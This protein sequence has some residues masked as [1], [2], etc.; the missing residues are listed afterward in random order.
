MSKF[1]EILILTICYG[2]LASIAT[3]P[4]LYLLF[5]GDTTT[6]IGNFHNP[7][8]PGTLWF[9]WWLSHSL[10]KGLDFFHTD[11]LSYPYGENLWCT[12]G[13][14]LTLFLSYPVNK[15]LGL[16]RGYNVTAFI[17]LILNCIAGFLLINTIIKN[18]Y[19]AFLGGFIIGINQFTLRELAGGRLDQLA[20]FWFL[21]FLWSLVKLKNTQKLKFIFFSALLFIL[22]ALSSWHYGIISILLVISWSITAIFK[23]NYL[24]FRS[25]LSALSIGFLVLSFVLIFFIPEF[26]LEYSLPLTN[27]D[28]F[29]NYSPFLKMMLNNSLNPMALFFVFRFSKGD[30]VAIKISPFVFILSFI[31][32]IMSKR[33]KESDVYWNNLWIIS[34]ILSLGPLLRLNL[35]VIKT[36][37]HTEILLPFYFLA[38]YIPFF[39]RFFWPNRFLLIFFVSSAI[40]IMTFIERWFKAKEN[41]KKAIFLIGFIFII[42]AELSFH[43]GYIFPFQATAIKVPDIYFK[44][45]DLPDGVVLELPYRKGARGLEYLY[46]QTIHKKK[47]LNSSFGLWPFEIVPKKHRRLI[48]NFDLSN[49]GLFV[50]SEKDIEYLKGLGIK[51]IV[52][53]GE[54][55]LIGLNE[56]KEMEK[57]LF[58]LLGEPSISSPG[59]KTYLF[60]LY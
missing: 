36:G 60:I 12:M 44:L 45:K 5:S 21:F 37:V 8:L 11:Y 56:L 24:F 46:Y 6:A 41:F 9:N 55:A 38:K 19:L 43:S 52:F 25:S 57:R 48:I 51:Y 26:N 3:Y 20:I 53:N 58:D 42:I 15:T 13:N 50:R 14:F 23:K 39:V 40:I 32:L 16:I 7:D 29:N 47:M 31:F 49:R 17:F 35:Q 33:R 1:K 18:K 28:L 27:I 30:S 2:I 22:V 4:L 54:R 34:I 10:E 59:S